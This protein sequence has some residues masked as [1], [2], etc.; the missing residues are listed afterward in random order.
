[1]K[2]FWIE[3][4]AVHPVF[5][6]KE[7]TL[8]VIEL[9]RRW[10]GLKRSKNGMK[11]IFLLSAWLLLG[12]GL[13]SAQT[14]WALTATR[15]AAAL[16]SDTIIKVI[17]DFETGKVWH[18]FQKDLGVK[19][20]AKYYFC[21]DRYQAKAFGLIGESGERILLPDNEYILHIAT[22]TL[23]VVHKDYPQG[24]AL[25]KRY[26]IS[27]QG[28]TLTDTASA[29][30]PDVTNIQVYR[31]LGLIV[32]DNTDAETGE[33]II[34][35]DLHFRPFARIKPFEEGGYRW[36]QLQEY[37]DRFV[38][39]AFPAK[40][41]GEQEGEA[42]NIEVD[43]RT[44]K[45]VSQTPAKLPPGG[46]Y[47]PGNPDYIIGNLR[48]GPTDVHSFVIATGENGEYIW[49]KDQI[50]PLQ[51]LGLGIH[52]RPGSQELVV[53]TQRT[54]IE[55]W[56]A[57]TGDVRWQN[58]LYPKYVEQHSEIHTLPEIN[59]GHILELDNVQDSAIAV[60]IGTYSENLVAN[61]Q[62]VPGIGL[63]ILSR[64]TGKVL[65]HTQ[66][67]GES[68]YHYLQSSERGYRIFTDKH[69]YSYEAQ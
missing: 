42:V 29:G 60:V 67:P 7:L 26:L 46:M 15:Q 55:Q 68:L 17:E 16:E 2:F 9:R 49:Q 22:D 14:N 43:A 27:P 39:T 69:I 3:H 40:E 19:E 33:Y 12:T 11:P 34:L 53:V 63:Y 5:K 66:L 62:P 21:V 36:Y 54:T 35:G 4:H 6:T 57:R 48:R 65:L 41:E 24:K 31:R 25:L 45:I 32:V 64:Q 56:D 28:L 59:V 61:F 50:L 1:M 8:Y 47:W 38:I 23:I 18:I 20:G 10:R 30:I 51:H 52:G 37:R 58:D 44:G 13:C